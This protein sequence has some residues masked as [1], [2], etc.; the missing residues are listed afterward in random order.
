MLADMLNAPVAELP[1]CY[2]VNAT[3]NLVDAGTLIENLWSAW[4]STVMGKT[5]NF[6]E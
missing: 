4:T 3:Q 1:M 6:W 2:D 5:M